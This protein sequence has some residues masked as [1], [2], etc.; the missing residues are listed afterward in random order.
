MS[1]EFLYKFILIGEQSTGKTSILSRFHANKFNEVYHETIGV[2]FLIKHVSLNDKK[3]KCQFWDAS[4]SEKYRSIIGAY[5]K[6]ANGIMAVYDLTDR[7]SFDAV[8]TQ[9]DCYRHHIYAETPI[10]VVGNKLDLDAD[11]Q[12]DL[13]E[14]KELSNANGYLWMEISAKTGQSVDEA[15]NRLI[16]ES[17]ERNES[18]LSKLSIPSV[19]KMT[20]FSSYTLPKLVENEKHL[21][22]QSVNSFSA[23][24]SVYFTQDQ[25]KKIIADVMYNL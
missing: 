2:D 24:S 14:L 17:F 22:T 12:V 21:N 5:F 25:S 11:R 19:D 15:F 16:K 3:V 13:T 1:V 4:G 8:R 7:A 9:L 23:S 18:T 20:K 6:G 10:M